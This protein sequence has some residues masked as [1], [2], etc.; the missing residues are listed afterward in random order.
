MNKVEKFLFDAG[1]KMSLKGFEPL[2]QIIEL[3][4]DEPDVGL[5]DL[6]NQVAKENGVTFSR[7]ERSVRYAIQSCEMNEEVSRFF[8]GK[9]KVT[10]KVFVKTAVYAIKNNL[11]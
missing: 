7:L 11:V 8:N 1:V 3:E 4:L 6:M 2:K 9:K 10:N 5:C